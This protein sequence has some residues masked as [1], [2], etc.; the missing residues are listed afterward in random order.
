LRYKVILT[1]TALSEAEGYAEFIRRKS[2]DNIASDHW[3]NGLLD[4][5]FTLEELPARCPSIPEQEDIDFPVHQLLYKSHRIIF[6]IQPG[7]VKVLRICHASRKAL[8]AAALSKN[9][10]R[11]K[12]S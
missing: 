2:N 8:T 4:S 9:V 11:S 7:L 6:Q 3:W 1:K 12:L 5:L 10:R